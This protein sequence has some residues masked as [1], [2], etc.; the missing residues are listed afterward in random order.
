MFSD[1]LKYL[2]DLATKAA[3]GRLVEICS[4]PDDATAERM[5]VTR[6]TLETF[7][8]VLSTNP[9]P[10]SKAWATLGR[11]E[12]YWL[13]ANAPISLVSTYAYVNPIVAVILGYFFG[14]EALEPRIYVAS[15]II[16]GAVIFIN[17]RGKPRVQKEAQEVH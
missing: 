12:V 4:Q 6:N 2:A 10:Y 14:N 16:I 3:L 17:S 5:R 8:A 1:A 15:A 9:K 7:D 13:L 11:A